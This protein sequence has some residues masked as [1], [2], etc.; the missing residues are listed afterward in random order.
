VLLGDAENLSFSDASF[1]TVVCT[2]VLEHLVLPQRAV[3][4]IRRVLR[5]GGVLIGSTPR[6][7]LIWRLRFLS[8]T[9]YH[10]EPFH[11]EFYSHEL[12]SLLQPFHITL[13]RRGFL[14]ANLF[15]VAEKK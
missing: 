6:R 14:G 8:S 3:R 2:E 12:Q 13:L 15:F 1:S 4:E 7:A 10:N 5:P 9:H 11:N